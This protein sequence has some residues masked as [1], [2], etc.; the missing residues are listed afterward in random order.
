MRRTRTAGIG[1]ALL[2]SLAL[3]QQARAQATDDF[4][5][6]PN[7][8]L[9][10]DTSGSMEYNARGFPPNDPLD[11]DASM[12]AYNE[13]CTAVGTAWTSRWMDLTQVLTGDI[14]NLGCF[15]HDRNDATFI[16]EFELGIGPV[17]APYDQGYFLP[18][19]R[20]LSSNCTYTPGVIDNTNMLGWDANAFATREN[21]SP[22][23][24]ACVTP[25]GQLRDGIIDTYRDR[26]R[27]GLFTFDARPDDGIGASG[28]V[29]GGMTMDQQAGMNGHWSYFNDWEG[30]G[31]SPNVGNPPDCDPALVLQI[32][33]VGARNPAA[34][35][36]EGRMV[37]HGRVYASLQETR[38]H[39]DRVQDTLLSLR[40]Y[41]ATPL[42]GMFHDARTFIRIDDMDDGFYRTPAFDTDDKFAPAQDPLLNTTLTVPGTSGSCREQYIILLSDGEPNLDMRPYC[43]NLGT[44]MPPID[45]NC[46]Y[47]RA[48]EIARDLNLATTKS[49]LDAAGTPSVKTFVI[50]FGIGDAGGV[51]CEVINGTDFD[52]PGNVCATAT[53]PLAACCELAHIAWEGGTVNAHFAENELALKAAL[54]VILD[55]IIVPP[56]SRTVPSFINTAAVLNG[57]TNVNADAVSYEFASAFTPQPGELWR[58]KLERKR[59][60][61]TVDAGDPAKDIASIAPVDV[62]KGDDFAA[63]IHNGGNPA[64]NRR[65]FT[66][67]P[68]RA[69]SPSTA[70]EPTWTIR[71]NIPIV[72]DGAGTYGTA[73]LTGHTSLQTATVLADVV[74]AWP[75]AMNVTVPTPQACSLSDLNQ[76]TPI[77]CARD[78]MRWNLG[79]TTISGPSN[80]SD[81]LLGAVYHSSP[82]VIGPP[83]ALT[84][85][86]SYARFQSDD[87]CSADCALSGGAA[88]GA[89]AP[90]GSLLEGRRPL[91]MYVSTVD[92]QLHAFKVA[93]S[94]KDDPSP[95]ATLS[96]NEVWSFVPP[97]VLP[98]IGSM[99]PNTPANLLDGRIAIRDIP[100]E[101][102]LTQAEDS[103]APYRTVLVAS[104]GIAG[105]YY[106]AL[107]ITRP[108]KPEFLWQL[109]T[110][111]AGTP[112][113]GNSA[114]EPAIGLIAYDDGSGVKEI[115]VAILPGG[116]GVPAGSPPPLGCPRQSTP[117]HID[118]TTVPAFTPRTSVRCW[119]AGPSKS[120]T[121]VRLEDG[122]ILQQFHY[123]P[124]AASPLLVAGSVVVDAD[125]DEPL[126]GAVAYPNGTGQVANRAY[127]TGQ[128][129]GIYRIGFSKPTPADWTF[130]LVFDAYP[131]GGDDNTNGQ[132]VAVLPSISTDKLGNTVLVFSTGDQEEFRSTTTRNRV[133]SITD[134]PVATGASS[135]QF[136]IE[137][138]WYITDGTVSGKTTDL[139]N[140]GME[141]GE[142]VTGPIA[143]FGGVAYF[144]TVTPPPTDEACLVG[145]G[146][147]WA[148]D[149]VGQ[150]G[151]FPLPGFVGTPGDFKVDLPTG[152]NPFGVAVTAE[153]SCRREPAAST[154][155]VGAH[156]VASNTAPANYV[157]RFFTGS[158]GSPDAL[159]S[160]VNVSKINIP[161]PETTV[162]ID[163]WASI[164]E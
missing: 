81:N 134:F 143:T 96:N 2:A 35:P 109:S 69:S 157:V 8:L 155:Y 72:G 40:P 122:E 41:G 91:M 164:V 100:L 86:A 98:S 84:S 101:R 12:T 48:W 149:Y 51:D 47:E 127:L 45:G 4:P 64:V 74:S 30:G 60:T 131:L 25:F 103:N 53:G 119:A 117:D 58:G 33:E 3:T 67:L 133:W 34:P 110:D 54:A 29:L 99:Y 112:I 62:N 160:T 113:F 125:I 31:P 46:P 50:G 5:P 13:D 17:A 87:A 144:S 89:C 56:T 147:V 15:S 93:A 115:A 20:A 104:G 135:R 132:R 71:P 156:N 14:L 162:T 108:E 77:P 65:F 85:D 82:R 106:F 146:R 88:C 68:D 44:G 120:V 158:G 76:S 163:S 90:S 105:G 111:A 136:H 130:D 80:R 18:H 114:G 23:G 142:K 83:S 11:V 102:T 19:H 92:G 1:T 37:N 55:S 63:N 57:A 66:A 137:S 16:S 43:E 123:Q 6:L 118:E 9:L 38:N 61:C 78:I 94:H 27:F 151:K 138:N 42:A 116:E 70:S 161:Q 24:T 126:L 128:D 153:P 10:V 95:A 21:G 75:E 73:G 154:D 79:M 141:P 139:S 124:A 97:Y 7:V 22:L 49:T 159:N 39:N 152:E 145:E 140:S 129:G 28:T 36:W 26:V 59:W 107:D 121:V 32:H 150:S 148:V 52:T